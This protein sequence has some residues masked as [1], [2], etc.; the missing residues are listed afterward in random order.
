MA[1]ENPVRAEKK[2]VSGFWRA[3]RTSDFVPRFMFGRVN[4]VLAFLDGHRAER[5]NFGFVRFH[6]ALDF[7]RGSLRGWRARLETSYTHAQRLPA[8]P[9]L[10]RHPLPE[11]PAG[12]CRWPGRCFCGCRIR[13]EEPCRVSRPNIHSPVQGRL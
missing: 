9:V 2:P 6:H 7:T 5:S 10:W 4:L 13:V 1:P 3:I 8:P 11:K 12:L